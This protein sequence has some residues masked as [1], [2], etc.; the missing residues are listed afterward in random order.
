MNTLKLIILSS[1]EVQ[2]AKFGFAAEDNSYS[3]AGASTVTFR[4]SKG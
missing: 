3:F 2:P 4:F 1:S